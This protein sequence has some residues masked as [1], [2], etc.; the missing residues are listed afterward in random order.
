MLETV[1]TNIAS[2]SGMAQDDLDGVIVNNACSFET[3]DKANGT[4]KDGTCRIHLPKP[5]S[6]IHRQNFPS[7]SSGRLLHSV[8]AQRRHPWRISWDG[9]AAHRFIL[10]IQ[11]RP[12]KLLHLT[13]DKNRDI[14]PNI[15]GGA[16]VYLHSLKV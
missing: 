1:L 7:M 11:P 10:A 6:Q 2:D 13:G 12:T 16:G 8:I 15:L 3:W 9:R 14:L 4:R 5:C